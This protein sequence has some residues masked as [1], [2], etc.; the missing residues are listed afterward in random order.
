MANHA[1]PTTTS[2]YTDV[3]S[4]IKTRIDDSLMMLDPAVT[5]VT[6]QPTNSIRWNSVNNRFEKWNGTAWA[7]LTSSYAIN[8]STASTLATARTIAMSGD[9]SWSVSFD[10]SIA[11]TASGTLSNTGVTAG[12][13]K[14]VTVDAKG[15]V[16]AGSNTAEALSGLT[17]TSISSPASGQVLRYNGS[18]WINSNYEY[19]TTV[20]W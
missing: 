12:T 4:N 7:V 17:D 14:N 2:L 15:R 5:T 10:G 1:L 20:E 9:V 11:V 3:I 19:T 6:N 18:V 16:T 13:Y 8:S